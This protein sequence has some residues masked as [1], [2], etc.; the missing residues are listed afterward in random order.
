MTFKVGGVP[1][2]GFSH[3]EASGTHRPAPSP[4][5][6][7]KQLLPRGASTGGVLGRHYLLIGDVFLF[8][9]FHLGLRAC[10]DSPKIVGR[11][12][13]EVNT[14]VRL[15]LTRIAY[16][17]DSI[18]SIWG[19]T[20]KVLKNGACLLRTGTDPPVW[21]SCLPLASSSPTALARK[22]LFQTGMKQG[23]PRSQKRVLNPSSSGIETNK[24]SV[25]LKRT[26]ACS[27]ATERGPRKYSRV[28][29]N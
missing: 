18:W 5:T 15:C 23:T 13:N 16:V 10:A 3:L 14:Y 24:S 27:R 29:S 21:W 28:I 1:G 9:D 12:T 26:M 17:R 6:Y 4:S 20:R 8:Y 11:P 22:G 25:G 7:Y 2:R 19:A